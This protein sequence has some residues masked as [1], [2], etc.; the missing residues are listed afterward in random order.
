MHVLL[1]K[2]GLDS[3]IGIVGLVWL[4]G[5]RLQASCGGLV[6]GVTTHLYSYIGQVSNCEKGLCG[7]RRWFL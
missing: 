3:T 6:T 4:Y 7:M 2:L 1:D 5:V